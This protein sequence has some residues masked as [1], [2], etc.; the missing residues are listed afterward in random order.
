MSKEL[1]LRLLPKLNEVE[2]NEVIATIELSK[3]KSDLIKLHKEVQ[4]TRYSNGIFNA[5]FVMEHML[6]KMELAMVFNVIFFVHVINHSAIK[7]QLL[8]LIQRKRLKFG[9]NILDV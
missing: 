4:E 8:P 9:L 6:S 2:L 5:R 3:F 1:I 7:H